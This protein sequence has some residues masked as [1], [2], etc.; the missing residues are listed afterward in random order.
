MEYY[1][2]MER[3]ELVIHA[4]ISMSVID[5]KTVRVKGCIRKGNFTA[6]FYATILTDKEE[7]IHSLIKYGKEDFIQGHHHDM[8]RDYWG[9]VLK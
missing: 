1:S 5:T 8:C 3:D 6:H 9:G 2:V 4:A 7:I